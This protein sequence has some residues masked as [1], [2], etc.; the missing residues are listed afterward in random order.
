MELPHIPDELLPPTHP[1]G[2]RKM[3]PIKLPRLQQV[4]TCASC[5]DDTREHIGPESPN[6][7][8]DCCSW[9]KSDHVR[10]GPV[11]VPAPAGVP[12]EKWAVMPRRERRAL[13]R[14]KL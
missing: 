1:D 13:L 14:R 2:P 6:Q 4:V 7:D 11:R 3:M 5:G 12:E 8:C 10:R 9:R